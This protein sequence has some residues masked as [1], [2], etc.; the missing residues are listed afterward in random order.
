[1]LRLKSFLAISGVA[2]IILEF[3]SLVLFSI[4]SSPVINEISSR[5]IFFLKTHNADSLKL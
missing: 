5:V 1:M 2:Q 3:Q 4:V